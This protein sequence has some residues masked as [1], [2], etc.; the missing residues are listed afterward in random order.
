M[1]PAT[2]E[3]LVEALDRNTA[4]VEQGVATSRA[5]LT[6]LCESESEAAKRIRVA[7]A[8]ARELAKAKSKARSRRT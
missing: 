1:D 8:E 5:L 6:V 7:K 4:A 2:L 3:A